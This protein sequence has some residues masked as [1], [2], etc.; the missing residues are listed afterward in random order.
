[1]NENNAVKPFI[2]SFHSEASKL[3]KRAATK[4]LGKQPKHVGCKCSGK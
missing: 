3:A 2:L 4:A 1:M